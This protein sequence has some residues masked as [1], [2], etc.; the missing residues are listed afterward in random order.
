MQWDRIYD[1]IDTNSVTWF[2]YS[3]HKYSMKRKEK[4]NKNEIYIMTQE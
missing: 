2:V 3:S 4:T 1:V